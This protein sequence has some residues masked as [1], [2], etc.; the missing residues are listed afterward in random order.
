MPTVLGYILTYV[1]LIK[2]YRRKHVIVTFGLIRYTIMFYFL[3]ALIDL[4]KPS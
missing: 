3:Y 4:P 1:A 2:H